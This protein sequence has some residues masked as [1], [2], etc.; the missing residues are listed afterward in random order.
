[1]Q[2]RKRTDRLAIAFDLSPDDRR[3][4]DLKTWAELLGGFRVDETGGAVPLDRRDVRERWESLRMKRQAP[5]P[6]V[7][8]ERVRDWRTE[9][10]DVHIGDGGVAGLFLAMAHHKLGH[11]DEAEKSLA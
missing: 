2:P 9:E 3:L 4:E 10:A 7:P 6:S 5:P 8:A 1:M 11:A